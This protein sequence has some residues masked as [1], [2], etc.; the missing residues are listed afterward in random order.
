MSR[1]STP[2]ARLIQMSLLAVA[3]TGCSGEPEPEPTGFP[4]GCGPTTESFTIDDEPLTPESFTE[5]GQ[6]IEQEGMSWAELDE[7]ERCAL[8]C[9]H[10]AAAL[11][12]YVKGRAEIGECSLT[13]EFDGDLFVAGTVSCDGEIPWRGICEGRRPLAW[14]EPPVAGTLAR[15][16]GLE[17]AS[18]TAFVELAEQLGH[19]G[20]PAAL[21]DRCR[22]AAAD[23][24][25]HVELLVGLGAPRPTETPAPTREASLLAIALHN[26]VE[27]CV[28]ETWAALLA[29][30]QAQR[31]PSQATRAAFMTIAADEAA[32][33]Q[34][35]WDLHAWLCQRLSPE[36]AAEVEAA[37]VAA[38]VGLAEVAVQQAKAFALADR[39]ALGLPDPAR[40]R[41]LADA[42]G[43]GLL[44][45]A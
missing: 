35:A 39:L 9:A 28:M 4:G 27:G 11:D 18:I 5:L 44:A 34:L 45:A 22:Q 3:A 24:A 41:A 29:A 16:V 26:A 40:A 42:F 33:A 37:R 6:A 10:A 14:V 2:I 12:T 20:A 30:D 36:Q 7:A 21:V 23:E 8:A 15:L 1:A 19:H 32:H 38:L 43:S 31:A 13:V 25:R 17:H